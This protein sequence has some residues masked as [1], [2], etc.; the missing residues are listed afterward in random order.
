[1][2]M[3]HQLIAM[4]AIVLALAAP[5]ARAGDAGILKGAPL[6][7]THG[8]V[9][10]ATEETHGP[11]DPLVPEACAYPF[12]NSFYLEED[13]STPTGYRV[14]FTPEALPVAKDKKPIDPTAWNT[15]D[16]FPIIPS[17][18]AYFPDVSL[19]GTA[20]HWDIDRSLEFDSPTVLLNADTGEWVPHFVELNE[21]GT[22]PDEKAFMMWPAQAL[23]YGT[24][25]IVA[26]RD[27]VDVNGNPI[28]PSDAFLALRDGQITTDPDIEFRREHY[29]SLFLTLQRAG[30]ARGDLQLVFDFV[31]A[32]QK[33]VT[34]W[35]L[36][37]RDD[38]LQRLSPNGPRYIIDQVDEW[39][40]EEIYRYIQ[41][42]IRVPLYL[43]T[44]GPS[45]RSRLVIGDNGLPAFQGYTWVRFN[46]TIPRSLYENPHPALILQDGHGLFDSQKEITYGWARDFI[47]KYEYVACAVDWWGMAMPDLPTTVVTLATDISRFPT[48]PDRLHQGVINQV[49]LMEFM[50]GPA[51]EDPAFSVNGTRVIDPAQRGYYGNSEGGIL[52]GTYMAV[53]T[54]VTRGVLGVGGS[55]YGLML[56]RSADFTPF[57]E[58][59][60]TRYPNELDQ[61][62]LIAFL[63]MV[64]DRA[65]PAG[66]V[67][68]MTTDPFPNTPEHQ[69]LMQ[70][71]IG[72]AQVPNLA[73]QV[74][75]RSVPGTYLLDP[76]AREVWNLEPMA[77]P[78]V[79]SGYVEFDFGVPPVPV[80][81]TPPD[82]EYDTHE[83]ARRV[84]EGQ[85]QIDHFLRT[86]ELANYCDGACDPD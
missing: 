18:L 17:I 77:A 14:H 48:L 1:M 43:T 9:A 39:P 53:S 38:T 30:V 65:E 51:V 47:D 74:Y 44:A 31:T 76:Y 23:D 79:G 82:E 85:D 54:R 62:F 75:A 72:D 55:P 67:H 22:H 63:Q 57:F 49:A 24:H 20:P 4:A 78:Y 58:I 16:G 46:A 7:G 83:D 69:V 12:P 86:G 42:R 68:H 19:D 2:K 26:I 41:G 66:Y 28:E 71:A 6:R 81:N 35:M 27:L 5:T 8:D 13:T 11:C 52:G 60:K 40:K 32:S 50:I 29:E 21:S 80:T 84:P 36:S 34:S 64:W 33:A 70:I 3:T 59:L 37:M 56:P 15:L 61:M 25:Y 73:S 10:R 45:A